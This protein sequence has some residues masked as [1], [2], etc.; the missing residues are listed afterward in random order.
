MWRRLRCCCDINWVSSVHHATIFRAVSVVDTSSGG[1]HR[2]WDVA[3]FYMV[4][5][6]VCNLPKGIH[7]YRLL[8]QTGCVD[9]YTF[10]FIYLFVLFYLI[11]EWEYLHDLYV[12]RNEAHSSS[13]CIALYCS[14]VM[15]HPPEFASL[16][17]LGSCMDTL[18]LHCYIL[19]C[20][21]GKSSHVAKWMRMFLYIY[22]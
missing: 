3:T 18:G 11:L 10:L 14:V 12:C 1:A 21:G 6:S 4:C 16:A 7:G 22:I 8:A 13:T 19:S 15:F 5:L 2:V 9:L 20:W 17:A